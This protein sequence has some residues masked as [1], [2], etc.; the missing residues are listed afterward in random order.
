MKL[1]YYTG[2][3]RKIFYIIDKENKILYSNKSN[4]TIGYT[5]DKRHFTNGNV[6]VIL[7]FD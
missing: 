7:T 4:N 2:H 6:K 5:F 1:I 3:N